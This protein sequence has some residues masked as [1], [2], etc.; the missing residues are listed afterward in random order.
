MRNVKDPDSLTN[1]LVFLKDA[2]I[3]NWHV[4]TA[5]TDHFCTELHVF[6]VERRLLKGQIR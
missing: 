2:G 3:E 6:W 5:E 1:C 4:P